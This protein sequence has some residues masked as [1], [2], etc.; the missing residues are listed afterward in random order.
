MYLVFELPKPGGDDYP[1]A[2]AVAFWLHREFDRWFERFELPYKTKFHKNNLR[3]IFT[4]DEEYTFFL[5]SWQPNFM[6]NGIR[7]PE[8]WAMPRMVNPP[9]H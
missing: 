3:L 1:S 5:L 6:L 2:H 7:I 8:H 9:K 4:K